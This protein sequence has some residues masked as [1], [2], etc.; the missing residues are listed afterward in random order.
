MKTF[1]STMPFAIDLIL[2]S[3]DSKS[4]MDQIQSKMKIEKYVG[5]V[6]GIH[7]QEMF[8]LNTIKQFFFFVKQLDQLEVCL[9]EYLY[10]RYSKIYPTRGSI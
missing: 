9:L 7:Q 3:A 8:Y 4:T 6:I 10:W 5:I 1:F 2:I